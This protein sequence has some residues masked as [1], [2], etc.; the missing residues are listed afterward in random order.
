VGQAPVSCQPG[1]QDCPLRTR[2]GHHGDEG[3]LSGTLS[4]QGQQR[5]AARPTAI[6]ST[7]LPADF[8]KHSQGS[9]AIFASADIRIGKR[10]PTHKCFSFMTCR[11]RNFLQKKFCHG[12]VFMPAYFFV[13][14]L[15]SA[16]ERS[17][18]GPQHSRSFRFQNRNGLFEGN[19]QGANGISWR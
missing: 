15:T 19:A 11:N 17:Q 12:R 5:T 18:A 13:G 6:V 14:G 4:P 2:P 8:L 7:N 16:K 1:H 9:D 10:L 3:V